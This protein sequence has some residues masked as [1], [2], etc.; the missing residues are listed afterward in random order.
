[1]TSTTQRPVGTSTRG[2]APERDASMAQLIPSPP[3]ARR[4]WGVLTL[5]VA[6][7]GLSSLGV[8]WLVHASSTAMSVVAARQ[9]I[10]RG[11]VIDAED[12]MVVQIASDPA[13][14]PV[15]GSQLSGLVGQRAALDVAAGSLLTADS[16][17]AQDVPPAGFSLVGVPV[18]DLM[19]P[20]VALMAGDEVR[21]VAMPGTAIGASSGAPTAISAV[22]V[23]T[24]A[25][26]GATGQAQTVVSVQVPEADAVPLAALAATGKAVIVLDSRDR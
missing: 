5:M 20:G 24:A 13:L 9:T 21:V 19:L 1:M 11:T 17:S 8:V 25:G 2:P 23:G 18:S 3:K 26:Q 16:V 6:V 14:R 4:R 7:V 12:L 22:V 10:P 15:P